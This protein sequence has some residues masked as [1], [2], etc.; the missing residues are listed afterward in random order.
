MP[1][2]LRMAVNGRQ[3]TLQVD[4]RAALVDVL[5]DGVG[6]T[7]AKIGCRTGHC[8]ACTVLMDG[9]PVKSCCVLAL[10]AEQA[11]IT[12]IEGVSEHGLTTVQEA[13]A[14]HQG[15]QCGYCTSGMV[16][17]ILDLLERC[18]EP[19]PEDVRRGIVGNL[20]RCTGYHN[21]VAAVMDAARSEDAPPLAVRNATL[22]TGSSAECY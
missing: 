19:E 1:E 5:R 18:P 14:R 9:R 2:S 20:C 6:L 3:E 11:E 21:I 13:L 16:L 22:D 10:D 4:P 8:G 15:L 17:S 12:T 7:G